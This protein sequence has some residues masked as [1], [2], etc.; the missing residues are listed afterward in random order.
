MRQSQP[1]SRGADTAD[2]NEK[3]FETYM[4]HARFASRLCP[5]RVGDNSLNPSREIGQKTWPN[6]SARQ[7][8]ERQTR[9][10]RPPPPKIWAPAARFDVNCCRCFRCFPLLPPLGSSP[11]SPS[12][13]LPPT[14]LV[15]TGFWPSAGCRRHRRR[16]RRCCRCSRCSRCCRLFPYVAI[17]PA[18]GFLALLSVE[19]AVSDALVIS[20]V[21]AVA[22]TGR[23]LGVLRVLRILRGPGGPAG[24]C[25]S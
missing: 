15:I 25:G 11:C 22:I 23:V 12:N 16:Y 18:A 8:K 3:R 7:R 2:R 21:L 4:C 1:G 6:Q 9:G 17:V 20:G 19:R 24:S 5:G 14:Q 13:G 10:A